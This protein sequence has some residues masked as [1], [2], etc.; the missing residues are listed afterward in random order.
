MAPLAVPG[1]VVVAHMLLNTAETAASAARNRGSTRCGCFGLGL[2]LCPSN[3]GP[4]SR[5]NH[6]L[7]ESAC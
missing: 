3:I 5:A 7:A 6:G 1:P 4:F 2:P